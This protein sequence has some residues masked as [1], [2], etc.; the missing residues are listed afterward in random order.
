MPDLLE[1]VMEA[2]SGKKAEEVV[3]I[4][5]EGRSTMAD[6]FVICTGRSNVQNRAIADAVEAAA[7]AEGYQPGRMEGYGDGNWIL[8]DLGNII[9]HVFTQEQREFYNLERLWGKARPQG[10]KETLA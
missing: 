10:V 5:L 4:P 7:V 3:S 1:L 6:A 2:A 9:V 8:I